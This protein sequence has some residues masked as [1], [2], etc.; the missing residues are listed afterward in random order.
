LAVL[1]DDKYAYRGT[2][3]EVGCAFGQNKSVVILC[4]GTS[5]KLSDDRY[6]Y[7]HYCMTNVFFHHPN[8]IHATKFDQVVEILKELQNDL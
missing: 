1:D 4:P 3:T 6:E 8:A 2:F 5:T 7:S